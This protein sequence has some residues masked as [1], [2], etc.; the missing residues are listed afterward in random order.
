[1]EYSFKA[2]DNYSVYASSILSTQD[3]KIMSVL[4]LPIIG[5]DATILYFVL[6]SDLEGDS[7]MSKILRPFS[8]L[9]NLLDISISKLNK[10]CD[11]LEAVG[12]IQRYVK[13]NHFILVLKSPK[14]ANAFFNHDIFR[15][16][17]KEK[18]GEEEYGRSKMYFA[19]KPSIPAGYINASKTFSDVYEY[20]N[21]TKPEQ[22]DLV[23]RSEGKPELNYNFEQLYS[24]L[25]NVSKFAFTDKIKEAIGNIMYVYN[26]SIVDMRS[27]ILKAYNFKNMS[28]DVDKIRFFASTYY[29]N[30][31]PL[32]KEKKNKDVKYS[33]AK[34][35][36]EFINLC[37]SCTPFEYLS[38]RDGNSP[39]GPDLQ[40][41]IELRNQFN[42]PSSV[43]NVIIE[44]A[45]QKNDNILPK[46]Y[47]LKLASS[48]QRSKINNAYDAIT[49]L[50]FPQFN[51]DI[52]VNVNKEKEN[53]KVDADEEN[54]DDLLAQI[55]RGDF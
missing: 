18:V 55:E 51:K 1:M 10:A 50:K 21:A 23:E 30:N 44:F 38:K 24:G 47:V 54:I 8:R 7:V 19:Y 29:P 11:H 13:D 12:L 45:L 5:M 14:S 9:S 16:M 52:K 43:L 33:G 36:D 48:L 2:K 25:G 4:Y 22:N 35:I 31:K 15:A 17:L 6:W 39:V 28:I 37:E 53:I 42:L 27:I 3:R 20:P 46:Q 32:I 34:D 49:K 26:I 41:L 40:L